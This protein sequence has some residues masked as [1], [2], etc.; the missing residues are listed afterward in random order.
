M[1]TE[2]TSDA[3]GLNIAMQFGF[4]CTTNSFLLVLTK[5]QERADNSE[6]HAITWFSCFLYNSF[7]LCDGEAATWVFTKEL[8]FSDQELFLLPGKKMKESYS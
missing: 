4:L 8:P 6:C 2:T 7:S 3:S 5:N 1:N